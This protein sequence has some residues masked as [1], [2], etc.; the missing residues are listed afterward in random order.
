MIAA[1][2]DVQEEIERLKAHVAAAR[3]LVA[4]GEPVGRRLEFLMQEFNREANTICSKSN[5]T[6]ISRAGLE[7]HIPSVSA[8][9]GMGASRRSSLAISSP[10]LLASGN[11][12]QGDLSISVQHYN[13]I[14]VDVNLV[15]TSWPLNRILTD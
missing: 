3:D 8:D 9:H 5:D 14:G 4:L 1:K 2:V 13:G 10:E 12:T 15:Q 11:V 7:R 6:E